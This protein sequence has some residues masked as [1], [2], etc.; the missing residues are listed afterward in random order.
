MH[1]KTDAPI[2]INALFYFPSRHMEKYGMG[3]LDPGVSLYS[4]KVLIQHNSKLILPEWCRFVKGVVD[5][6]DIPL[7][8]SREN[9]QDS[10]LIKRMNNVLTKRIIK[11]LDSMSKKDAAKFIE[12]YR[13]FSSFIK[14]GVCSDAVNKDEIARLLRYDTS[15]DDKEQSSLDDYI[16]RMPP[17]QQDIF[18]LYAPNRKYALLSPYFESFDQAGTEVI[19]I[20]GHIDDFVMKNLAKYNSRKLVSIESA[21]AKPADKAKDEPE[22]TEAE[23]KQEE[24]DAKNAD[25]LCTYLRDTLDKLVSSVT[26]T[27]RLRDSPAIVVDHES[28]TVRKMMQYVD[29]AGHQSELPKQK[30]QINPKHPVMQRLIKLKGSNPELASLVAHQVFDNALI[31]ADIMENPRGM[32][33]RLND[34]LYAAAGADSASS[35]TTEESTPEPEAEVQEA[36]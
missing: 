18:Y 1:F 35:Q 33:A 27:S 20:Y 24:I 32:L 11:H 14:E 30:L 12:F 26:S 21:K 15:V 25:A 8:I 28:A 36:K 7:N 17:E 31:A 22:K 23:K 29:A 10:A 6:E 19:F 5:S 16:G 2:D 34:I 13:E 4:R 3:R 9:M